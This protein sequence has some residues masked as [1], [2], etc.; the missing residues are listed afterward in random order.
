[1]FVIWQCTSLDSPVIGEEVWFQ[2]VIATFTCAHTK[3]GTIL[4]MVKIKVSKSLHAS[5]FRTVCDIQLQNVY[6]STEGTVIVLRVT[7]KIKN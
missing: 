3:Y 5:V 2:S 6:T 4:V 1:M 7:L